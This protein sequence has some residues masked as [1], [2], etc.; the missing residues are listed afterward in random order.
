MGFT[1]DGKP[2]FVSPSVP[3]GQIAPGWQQFVQIWMYK[4]DTDVE[5]NILSFL[6]GP[7]QAGRRRKK[8]T[9]RRK[10]RRR[11]RGKRKGKSR[12]RKR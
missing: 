12:R 9:R 11:M 6:F 2:R 1:R 4:A 5:L 10:S 7:Q 8:R 3:G